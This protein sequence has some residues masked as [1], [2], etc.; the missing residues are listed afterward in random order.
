MEET[1][2]DWA[3]AR[4]VTD[5]TG[6]YE[7]RGVRPGRGRLRASAPVTRRNASFDPSRTDDTLTGEFEPGDRKRW[8]AVLGEAPSIV[9]VIIDEDG[10]GLVNWHVWA[11]GPKG[12]YP[13]ERA[14]TD[15]AWS[16]RAAR[17]VTTTL[18][19]TC[20]RVPRTPT[21]DRRLVTTFHPADLR[22]RWSSRGRSSRAVT[23][24]AV[25]SMRSVVELDELPVSLTRIGM[26][27]V[28]SRTSHMA[29]GSFRVGPIPPGRYE[30]RGSIG[31]G[32]TSE[33]GLSAPGE[34]T[35]ESGGTVDLG[36]KALQAPGSLRLRVLTASGEEL[37][38]G[39]LVLTREGER[40]AC[41]ALTI[42]R[43]AASA[44][45][46]QPGE[47]L[48]QPSWDLAPGF[49][50]ERATVLAGE[51]SELTL[52]LPYTVRR[53]LRVPQVGRLES[54]IEFEWTP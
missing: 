30:A 18:R 46:L 54:L 13:P 27:R 50:V 9:G 3:H 47:Y 22:S 23:W 49:F 31:D 12:A 2:P 45:A 19:T 38:S 51:V 35:V 10:T 44:P 40:H 20:S 41:M 24:S 53:T 5:S 14:V 25:S 28:T 6:S 32:W 52:S 1:R 39:R 48:V 37:T 26:G 42:D 16:L 34:F 29:A 7:L 36:T 33:E 17:G 4:A 21:R 11:N 8:D 15:E 43:G